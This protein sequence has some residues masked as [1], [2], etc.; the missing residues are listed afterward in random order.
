MPDFPVLHYLVEPVQLMLIEL[1]IPS[2]HLVLCCPL[3]LLLSIF[4][5]IRVFSNEF[6]LHIG[7]QSIGASASVLTMNI[8]D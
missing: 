8:Q 7:G 1:V 4:P 3:L 6:S 5:S 2:S